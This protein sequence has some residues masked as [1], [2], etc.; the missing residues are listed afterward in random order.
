MSGSDSH[1]GD[2]ILAWFY[3]NKESVYRMDLRTEDGWTEGVPL[4]MSRKLAFATFDFLT[5]TWVQEVVMYRDD[6][7]IKRHEQA[8]EEIHAS[9]NS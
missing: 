4:T 8:K 9:D 3:P 2:N 7:E 1:I 6:K 5:Q